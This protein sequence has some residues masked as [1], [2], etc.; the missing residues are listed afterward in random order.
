[1]PGTAPGTQGL[2]PQPGPVGPQGDMG[3]AGPKGDDGLSLTAIELTADKD[4]T[5]TGG[6]GTLSDGSTIP[7]TV[8]RA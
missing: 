7:I 8:K 3:P 1:M 5:I 4:G 6:T 2:E